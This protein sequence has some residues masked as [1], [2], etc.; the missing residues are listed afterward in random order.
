MSLDWQNILSYFQ[1][2][3]GAGLLAL[4]ILFGGTAI[5]IGLVFGFRFFV[6][7]FSVDKAYFDHQ[8]FLIR[9]PKEKP[10]DENKDTSLLQMREEIAKG[11]TIFAS[12]GGL[13]AQRGFTAWLLG[14]NDHFA[15]E[16]VASRN[17]IAFYAAAP[18]SLARYLEQQITAHYPEAVVEEIEDYNAFGMNGQIASA[19][20]K[21]R[22]SFVLPLRTYQ[23]IEVDPLNSLI[24]IMSK[25]DKDESIA[26]QY[27]VSS[28]YGR[29]LA[30]S[31][32]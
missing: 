19:Y 1:T 16:I 27:V 11:E 2:D 9:L 4:I 22:K 10:K 31:I 30:K 14:R 5:L 17:K 12:I 8:I 28:A 24:N 21:T 25:L 29:N 23:K 6:R 7:L 32:F 26:V 13:K 15:F 18:K 20:L 3:A